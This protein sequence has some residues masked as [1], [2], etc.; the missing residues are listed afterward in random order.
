MKIKNVEQTLSNGITI[1]TDFHANTSTVFSPDG[2][3]D[4]VYKIDDEA[5]IAQEVKFIVEHLGLTE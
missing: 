4:A 1:V 5:G 3:Y 2:D